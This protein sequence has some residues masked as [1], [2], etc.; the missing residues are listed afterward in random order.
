MLKKTIQ[1]PTEELKAQLDEVQH[2]YMLDLTQ[3]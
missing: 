3:Y 1:L 2:N